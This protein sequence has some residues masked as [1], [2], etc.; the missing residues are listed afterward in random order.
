MKATLQ[1]KPSLTKSHSSSPQIAELP[2]LPNP[3]EDEWDNNTVGVGGENP[4]D[5][6][7]LDGLVLPVDYDAASQE[8][9]GFLRKI[10]LSPQMGIGILVALVCLYTL[11]RPCVIGEC[12]EI[13]QAKSLAQQ[14]QNTVETVPSSR[15]PGLAKK[16]IN[17]AIALL[18]TIPWWSP[19]HLEARM[20]LRDYRQEEQELSSVVTALTMAGQA[21][22]MGQ[23]PPHAI[24][25]W[26]K[27]ERLWEDAIVQL[28]KVRPESIIY[29]FTEQRL[30]Q[31]R[32]NLA[33]VRGRLKLEREAKQTLE[34]AKKTA[35]VAQAREGVAKH[36]DSWQLVYDT[37]QNATNTL[38]S[39]PRG[40]TAHQEAQLLLV[41]Y[42]PR[43]EDARD[44]KTIEQVGLEAYNRAINNADQAQI[45]EERKAWNEASRAWGR[46]VSFANN[47]PQ[48]S[49]YYL[50]MQSLIPGY[51]QAWQQAEVQVKIDARVEQAR[52]DLNRTCAGSPKICNYGIS[53][54]LITVRLTGE[55]VEKIKTTTIMGDRAGNP[56]QRSQAENH[57]KTLIIA[58]E[59]IS[60]NAKIPLQ[61]YMPDGKKIGSHFPPM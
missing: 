31:Y 33:E 32:S 36:A 48:S 13:D 1:E 27:M 4:F 49:S 16:E 8:S 52:V 47:V 38:A 3:F 7:D 10:L 39:V 14:S 44:R 51:N 18:Q 21:A 2:D 34:M 25:E 57:V 19:Y 24:E 45:F 29:P 9:S 6:R 12:R 28:Q 42:Q 5:P 59:S 60:D 22:E 54:D 43:L 40:T 15:A 53:R 61:V 41:R 37:W 56:Q 55:Y 46:A 50:E 23:N 20:L 35:Q 30:T 58:L 26:Q 17:G 11:T